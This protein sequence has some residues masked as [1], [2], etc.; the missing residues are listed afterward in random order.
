[1]ITFPIFQ[2][3]SDTNI[4]QNVNFKDNQFQNENLNELQL[5]LKWTTGNGLLDPGF[6]KFT[7]TIDYA[8]MCA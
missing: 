2:S 4:E 7:W 5:E 1:M 6:N 3:L 8:N